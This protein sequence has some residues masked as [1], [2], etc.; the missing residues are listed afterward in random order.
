V[1]DVNVYT[2]SCGPEFGSTTGGIVDI[3]LRDPKKNRLGGTI[4]VSTAQASALLEG[5][6][7]DSQSFYLGARRSYLDLIV[8]KEDFAGEEGITV[9]Q[10]PQYYD[11]QAKYVWK[12]SDNHT[13]GI[14]TSGAVDSLKLTFTPDYNLVKHDPV[15]EGDYDFE[16]SYRTFGAI[17]ASR[18]SGE[19]NNK[20]GISLL[21]SNETNRWSLLG[22]SVIDR[23]SLFIRDQMTAAVSENHAVLFG[24]EYDATAFNIDFDSANIVPSEWNPPPDYTSAE[25]IA[26]DQTLNVDTVIIAL[27]DRWNIAQPLTLVIGAQASWDDYLKKNLVEP[28]LSAEYNVRE[29]TQITAGWGKYH[30]YPHVLMLVNGLGNPNLDYEKADQTDLGI[31]QKLPQGW[32]VKLEEY[33]KRL[34]DLA[35]PDDVENFINGGSG[36]A[37]GT[38]LSFTK[39][40]NQANW[41]G[42]FSVAYSRSLRHNDVT[43]ESFPSVY[44]QPWI[45]NMSYFRQI[46]PRWK[47]SARWRFQSGGTFTPVTRTYT[48]ETGRIRPVYGELNSERLPS[49]HRLDLKITSEI[50]SGRQKVMAY[51]DIFNAYNQKNVYGYDYNEDY[52]SRKPGTGMSFFPLLGVETTF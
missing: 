15:F 4:D 8:S 40:D 25:R 47:F 38:E 48:D 2:S 44:D 28:K 13:A 29:G 34:Y 51:I 30:N 42:R 21:Q 43:G 5:P 23:D 22:H 6:I 20:V 32:S 12:P 36:K 50:W 3:R 11:Y 10:V 33:Y 52:T 35:V 24:L 16:K 17:L 31:E 9:R 45:V 18:I 1:E 46:T 39:Q 27:K 14:F 19:V 7:T 26:V 41:G 37:Y 49:T